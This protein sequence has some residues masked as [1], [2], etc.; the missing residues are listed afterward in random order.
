MRSKRYDVIACPSASDAGPPKRGRT[1]R[2]CCGCARWCRFLLLLL[3]LVLV[4]LGMFFYTVGLPES[5]KEGIIAALCEKGWDIEFSRLRLRWYRGI[6]ADNLHVQR[7]GRADGPHLFVEEAEGRLNFDALIRL[8]LDVTAVAMKGGRLMLPLMATN[9]PRQTVRLDDIHGE[10][11]F[12]PGDLWNLSSIRASCRGIGVQ[13]SGTLTN[14]SAVRDWK[15]PRLA[16]P[17]SATA[18]E[19]RRRIWN[20]VQQ[21]RFGRAPEVLC[22]FQADAR[23]ADQFRAELRVISQDLDSP[24]GHSRNLV[25]TVAV[26]PASGSPGRFQARVK[27]KADRAYTPWGQVEKPDLQLRSELLSERVWPARGELQFN[28]GIPMSPWGKVD[29]CSI[30]ARVAP[31]GPSGESRLTDVQVELAGV[32]SDWGSGVAARVNARLVHSATNALDST[33][34]LEVEAFEPATRQ[35]KADCAR[36]VV[37]ASL[38]E[39]GRFTLFGTN[40]SWPERIRHLPFSATITASNAVSPRL[41]LASLV[42]TSR[43]ASPRLQMDSRGAL[44]GG[45]ASLAADLDAETRELRFTAVA[46]FDPH[47]ARYLLATNVQ[48]VLDDCTWDA[49][50]HLEAQGRGILSAWTNRHPDWRWEVWPTLSLD[51]NVQIGSG[52]YRGVS[53]RSAS[54]PVQLTNEAWRLPGILVSRP[55]GELQVHYT[56][57]PDTRPRHWKVRSTVDPKALQP[58]LSSPAAQRL[59]DDFALTVPPHFEGSLSITGRDRRRV[60]LEGQV[61]ITNFS[62]RGEAIKDCVT[63]LAYRD[64]FLSFLEPQ[65]RREGELGNADGVGVDLVTQMLFLTNAVGNLNA[66]A[67]CRAIGPHVV[68]AIQPYVFSNSPSGR[69]WG[70]IDLTGRHGTDDVYFDVAG[71]P[72][73]WGQ[74]R[75]PE[76][77]GRVHW[78]GRTV[79]LT[80]VQGKFYGGSMR[81]DAY[82]GLGRTNGTEFSYRTWLTNVDLCQF[83]ADV[84]RKTNHLEGALN[85]E[86][87]ITRA[88]TTDPQSWFGHGYLTLTNGMIWDIPIFGVF[89][90]VLNEVAPGLGNSRAK[91]G[92]ATF[93][94]TNSVIYSG[95]LQIH[96]TAMRMQYDMAVGFDHRVEGRVEAELL[97]DLPGLGFVVSKVFWPVTKMFEFRVTGS[98]DQPK[99]MPVFFIPRIL[100]LPFRPIKTIKELFPQEPTRQAPIPP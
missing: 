78:L 69:V 84:S 82:F 26:E 2:I 76:I 18:L 67:I 28:S 30:T 91:K 12:L 52:A 42:V 27:A 87:V 93:I 10:V 85:G 35:G 39:S 54:V 79:T 45:W 49:P 95:D 43:W 44:F 61:G 21:V 57:N 13:L 50:P 19:W 22:Q 68:A 1:W 86:L 80:N 94:I 70:T 20:A 34:N 9:P 66:Y 58:L 92:S 47:H 31:S 55:E 16:E 37:S 7:A 56:G 29:R 24:L 14:A 90:P 15:A 100:L 74:F 33:L 60:E 88:R 25:C 23:E 75:W 17:P 11:R 51:G 64:G 38:P 53:F 71:G 62:F 4:I 77:S 32:Q 89:S 40:L 48:V 72:F 59:L 65:V 73:R 41:A 97:R 36:A 46:D 99:A 3:L 96:A 8:K 6:V 83:M 81:G 5:A 98:L 63:R